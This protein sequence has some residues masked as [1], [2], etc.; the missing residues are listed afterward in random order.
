MWQKSGNNMPNVKDK[1]T[2]TKH[3]NSHIKIRYHFKVLF[4]GSH[5]SVVL[6]LDWL[7]DKSLRTASV[8]SAGLSIDYV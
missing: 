1:Y 4:Y 7:I 2:P 3:R 5:A 8:L 6:I